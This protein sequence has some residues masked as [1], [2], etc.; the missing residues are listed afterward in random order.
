[1]PSLRSVALHAWVALSITLFAAGC[2][3]PPAE[4]AGLDAASAPCAADTDCTDD[5]FCNGAERC[6]PDDDDGDERGCVAATA[7]RCAA[8][9]TCDEAG[10]TCITDCDLDADADGD[11]ASSTVCGGDDCDDSDPLRHPGA[12][13][14]C[15][16]DGR[17]EDCDP[18]TFGALDADDDGHVSA[19]CCNGELCGT[20]CDDAEPSVNRRSPEVCNRR[21]D[22]C[23]GVVDEGVG[24]TPELCNS[25]DD[26]CDGSVDEGV[27]APCPAGFS[28]FDGACTD[29]D[30]CMSGTACHVSRACMNGPGTY[31]CGPCA[32]GYLDDGP[33]DCADVNECLDATDLCH[34][35]RVCSNRPGGYTCEPCAA[36]YRDAGDHDCTNIDE[37][38]EALDA[39]D[40]IA[41]CMDA[42]PGY[43]CECPA[44]F[45][46]ALDGR[47]CLYDVA[48]LASLT[49]SAGTLT[50]AL[51]AG[52]GHTVLVPEG[53]SS[54]TLTPSVE[55]P[56]LASIR[57]DGELIGSGEASAPIVLSGFT[58]RVVEIKVRAESGREQTYRVTVAWDD[59]LCPEAETVLL[60][61]ATGTLTGT[62]AGASSSRGT[63]CGTYSSYGGPDRIYSFRHGG[64]ETVDVTV[65][66]SAS[67]DHD[68]FVLSSNRG[69][70]DPAAECVTR[71]LNALTDTVTFAAEPG[72]IRY[73]AYDVY[74]TNTPGPFSLSVSCAP[75]ACGDGRV[76]QGETCD[77]GAQT[78]GDGCS[79]SCQVEPGH[80]CRD[81]P[82]TCSA[83]TTNDSCVNAIPVTADATLSE[84][85]GTGP[86]PVGA[87]CPQ[88]FTSVRYARYYAITVPPGRRAHASTTSGGSDLF[89]Q[90]SCEASGCQPLV[91]D[92]K[93]VSVPNTG[94]TPITRIV[95]VTS[96]SSSQSFELSV[97]Y[98][99]AEGCGDGRLDPGEGCDDGGA[100]G[101]DGCSALCALEPGAACI[102]VPSQCVLGAP[103][104]AYCGEALRVTGDTVLTDQRAGRGGPP[105][106]GTGCGSGAR[107]L[108]YEVE[109]PPGRQVSVEV[110]NATGSTSLF[111]A[112][113]CDAA[114]CLPLATALTNDTSSTLTRWVG[115]RTSDSPSASF[116]LAFAYLPTAWTPIAGAC[117]DMS[118]GEVV[119]LG[120]SPV[121]PPLTGDNARTYTNDLPFPFS[122]LGTPVQYW[123]ASTNGL[124]ELRQSL[125]YGSTAY[126]NAAIPTTSSP[127]GFV[128]A[129]WDDLTVDV[130]A[131]VVQ[132]VT[133]APGSQR[134]VVEWRDARVRAVGGSQISFQ[135][136]LLEGSN[137]IELHYCAASGSEPA[138]TGGGATIGVETLSGRAGVQV[139]HNTAGHAVVGT[140]YRLEP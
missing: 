15:D 116:D 68:L 55:Q 3:S 125:G 89:V 73:L 36:G 46:L 40:A 19:I 48:S 37:C 71:S 75:I 67:S 87:Y 99:A 14:I 136:H 29:I 78:D 105:P 88:S 80:V 44:G 24:S 52:S 66:A 140:G 124:L 119:R 58:P 11:G 130:G 34:P 94:G 10:D 90:E 93:S 23:D 56:A 102:G 114:A 4:D 38:A 22:D 138:L 77:D 57:M 123:T 26:D 41:T 112:D 28:G 108:Y 118:A 50:P 59:P 91:G 120:P 62:T 16:E 2:G 32:A 74:A 121:E 45:V 53:T 61:C 126:A 128:T 81:A 96:V 113:A 31:S 9:Q 42:T 8:T 117:V 107:A 64:P 63:Y 135:V 27:C 83:S 133:G 79:A 47:D 20:D 115:V 30:E 101:G 25:V 21:D 97:R 5:V 76:S 69:C 110:W 65:S 72:S 103:D 132:L 111:A 139:S 70:A 100:V 49:P 39:C 33:Y 134:F 129:F 51:G 1:M 82:S 85:I 13:E 18:T 12:A 43:G 92:L 95:G 106:T 54:I 84:S 122:L 104:H 137:A 7:P 131:A 98:F 35:A 6:A 17:D 109:I 127:N 86:A 60:D